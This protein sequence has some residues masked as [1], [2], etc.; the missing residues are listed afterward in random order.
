M[1]VV[2]I[3]ME[4][5]AS[6]GRASGSRRRRAG[7]ADHGRSPDVEVSSWQVRGLYVAPELLCICFAESILI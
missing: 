5:A 3:C 2:P 4:E 6:S 7:P 1:C